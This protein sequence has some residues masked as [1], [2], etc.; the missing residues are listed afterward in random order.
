MRSRRG[1]AQGRDLLVEVAALR[2]RVD[3]VDRDLEESRDV[4]VRLTEVT[5]AVAELLLP[6]DQRDG[7]RVRRGLRRPGPAG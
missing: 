2:A 4:D 6:A 5:A 3:A 1:V 7:D